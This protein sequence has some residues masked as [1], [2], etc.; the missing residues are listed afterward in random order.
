M[1]N[2]FKKLT[3]DLTDARAAVDVAPAG[4][5][6]Y[7]SFAVYSCNG[8]VTVTGQTDVGED[9]FDLAVSGTAVASPFILNGR[10][11]LLTHDADAGKTMVIYMGVVK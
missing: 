3:L 9:S 10:K 6:W 11:L 7:D 5:A 8:T 4:I 1:A 2:Q